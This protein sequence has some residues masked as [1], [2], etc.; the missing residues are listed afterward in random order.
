MLPPD[1]HAGELPVAYV[2][3][4]AGAGAS[5]QELMNFAAE[6]HSGARCDPETHQYLAGASDDCGGENIQADIA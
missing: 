2:Q 5:E 1:A 3:L 4:K 6:R